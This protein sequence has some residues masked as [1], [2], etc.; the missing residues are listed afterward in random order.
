MLD[1]LTPASIIIHTPLSLH[2][3]ACGLSLSLL[4][5]APF[6]SCLVVHNNIS[7]RN[8]H[9]CRYFSFATLWK[10]H[11]CTCLHTCIHTCTHTHKIYNDRQATSLHCVICNIHSYKERIASTGLPYNC[12]YSMGSIMQSTLVSYFEL[13]V[14]FW[15]LRCDYW[16]D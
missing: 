8:T 3:S 7:E 10:T 1:Q 5:P 14:Y 9:L 4:P 6:L 11:A 13:N 12:I 2:P 16:K 15:F